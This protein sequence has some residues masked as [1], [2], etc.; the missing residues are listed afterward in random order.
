[1]PLTTPDGSTYTQ[2]STW[3]ISGPS[4]LTGGGTIAGGTVTLDGPGSYT[5]GFNGATVTAVT[6]APLNPVV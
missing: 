1:M 3:T 6:V 4:Y 5:T 2:P